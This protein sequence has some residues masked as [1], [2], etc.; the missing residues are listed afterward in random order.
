VNTETTIEQ[1]IE[2]LAAAG[3][4]RDH[5]TVWRAPDGKLYLGPYGAWK[6]MKQEA[7]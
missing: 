4:V 2:Q 6:Q 1:M 7:R 5:S 3:W